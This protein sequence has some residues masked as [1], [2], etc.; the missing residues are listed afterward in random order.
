VNKRLRLVAADEL[1]R[2]GQALMERA[3]T[4]DHWSARR[5]AVAYRDGLAIAL[6]AHR[7]LRMKNFCRLRIGVELRQ[8]RGVWHLLL[9]GELT[10]TGQ[11]YEVAFPET[12]ADALERYLAEHRPVLLAGERGSSHQQR[13][14]L[15][16]ADALWIS[17]TGTAW[18]QGAMSRRIALTVEQQ[19]GRRVPPHW[20]RDAAATTI[21]IDT[22]QHI[23]DAHHVLGHATPLTT[24]KHYIQAQSLSASRRHASM[25]ADLRARLDAPHIQ[26]QEIARCVP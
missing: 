15:H 4:E 7:P 10:K 20:F 12:L 19:L 1:V 5:G 18:E 22:P 21:A 13:R 6:L 24:E 16:A 2:C 14:S 8:E 3:E 25:L 26:D 17:E 23:A 9:A 11:P